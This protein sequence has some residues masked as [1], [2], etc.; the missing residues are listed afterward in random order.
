MKKS[1]PV[2]IVAVLCS[3]NWVFAQD[4]LPGSTSDTVNTINKDSLN[5]NKLVYKFNIKRKID[6]T[7]WR[8]T[9]QSIDKAK[10][11]DADLIF[12]HMNTYGGMVIS[13]DSIR[14]KIL[15]TEIPVYVFVDNNA[16]SAGALISIA[17]DR[18]YMRPGGNIGAATVVNQ[19]GKKM[20]D[21]YQ[22]Y[23]RATMRSTAE[24]QGKD[25]IIAGNDTTYKWKRDP[26]IAEAMVDESIYIDGIID[27]GK[28][29]T[30]T[31]SEA[32]EYGYCEG[33]A[34]SVKEVLKKA[35]YTNYKLKEF[36]PTAMDKILGTLMSPVLQSIFIMMII[37]GIY[38]EIQSPGIGFALAVAV[39]GA[40]LYFAPLYLEG[41]AENWEVLLFI[42][43]LVL[44]ALEIFVIPGFGIAGISGIILIIASLTLSLV[45]NFDFSLGGEFIKPVFKSLFLVVVSMTLALI[46]SIYTTK[47]LF[48][49]KSLSFLALQDTQQSEE[50]YIGV[51]NLRNTMK[52]KIGTAATNLR[53]SGKVLVDDEEYDAQAMIGFIERGTE[54]QVIKYESGRLHVRPKTSK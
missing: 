26:K 32:M 38:F 35:G 34:N 10:A 46:I 11:L 6:P 9:Q 15:N 25:T 37:G 12:I 44:I 24:A 18:I 4:S 50:G 43:G 21:K 42:A 19:E 39:L 14:T 52:G 23:M 49:S 33:T 40:L 30:F 7:A 13:A 31:A 51:E 5:H 2:F 16:A 27:T 28:V 53:P 20:P 48:T 29:L 54:V 8:N 41:L 1:L 17:C 22:S 45:E 36:T 3:L 47:K